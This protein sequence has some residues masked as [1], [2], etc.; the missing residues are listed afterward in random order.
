[1]N[2]RH[3]PTPPV[4]PSYTSAVPPLIRSTSSPSSPSSPHAKSLAFMKATTASITK[5]CVSC[6]N[7]G[8]RFGRGGRMKALQVR[9]RQ[10]EAAEQRAGRAIREGMAETARGV[11]MALSAETCRK[12]LRGRVGGRRRDGGGGGGG[13]GGSGVPF[14]KPNGASSGVPS[15]S[16]AV[17]C[18]LYRSVHS[19]TAHRH[20]FAPWRPGAALTQVREGSVLQKPPLH[21]Y[22]F[23]EW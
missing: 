17:L 1:M 18:L 20:T 21:P 16:F 14:F 12:T 7:P 9:T 11:E 13:G 10:R 3:N 19:A 2:K 4:H 23:A 5:E 6:R 22:T 15:M 8:G